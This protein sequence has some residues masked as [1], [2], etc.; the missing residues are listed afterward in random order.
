[1]LSVFLLQQESEPSY[2]RALDA[3]NDLPPERRQ[4]YIERSEAD[5]V[6]SI[7][8][9]TS[10][11]VA[12]HLFSQTNWC[13]LLLQEWSASFTYSMHSIREFVIIG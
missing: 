3:W 11:H 4:L 6:D 5:K 7:V 10:V 13:N 8:F 9:H 1:M 2:K 12:V